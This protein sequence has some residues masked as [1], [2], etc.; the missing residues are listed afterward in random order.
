MSVTMF[1]KISELC[2][3]SDIP[4]AELLRRVELAPST[5]WSA[6]KRGNALHP[7]FIAKIAKELGVTPDF[8]TN[9]PTR[10]KHVVSASNYEKKKRKVNSFAGKN[11]TYQNIELLAGAKSLSMS[12][13]LRM[14]DIKEGTYRTAKLMNRPINIR[15]LES[16]AKA[17]EVSVEALLKGETNA[18]QLRKL[19]RQ[20]ELETQKNKYSPE[21]LSQLVKEQVAK[22]IKPVQEELEKNNRILNSLLQKFS[23]LSRFVTNS[24]V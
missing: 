7:N 2:E 14:A 5:Y 18:R 6:R 8:L 10:M 21:E 20:K 15:N 4:I 11:R 1:Q 24:N 9:Y 23:D 12:E 13:V 16:L 22:E 19:P 17:L 3:N